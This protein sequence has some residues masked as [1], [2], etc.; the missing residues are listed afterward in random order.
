MGFYRGY[1]GYWKRKWKLLY[2][3]MGFYMGQIAHNL[4]NDFS[5]ISSNHG[6]TG[7]DS[8]LDVLKDAHRT[9]WDFP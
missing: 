2:S 9:M 7:E 8:V 1:I 3:K 4:K 6:Y 5:G